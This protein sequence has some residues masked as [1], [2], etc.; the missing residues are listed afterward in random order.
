M[1]ENSVNGQTS[2]DRTPRAAEPVVAVG[3]TGLSWTPL[4]SC[5]L[6]PHTLAW[7]PFHK[8][9]P[10]FKVPTWVDNA[11]VGIALYRPSLCT[12]PEFPATTLWNAGSRRREETDTRLNLESK[13]YMI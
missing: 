5:P 7:A 8:S 1:P 12:I 9:K 4:P 13:C 2:P 11:V 10:G 6:M 3:F